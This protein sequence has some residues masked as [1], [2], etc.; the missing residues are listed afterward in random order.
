MEDKRYKGVCKT[1]VHNDHLISPHF[2]NIRFCDLHQ[3]ITGSLNSC[4]DY[5][6]D[7]VRVIKNG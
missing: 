7:W 3:Y 6:E 5:K 2:K 4:E 1:C